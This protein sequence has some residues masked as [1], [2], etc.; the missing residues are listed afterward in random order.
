[1]WAVGWVRA[2][3]PGRPLSDLYEGRC[4]ERGDGVVE[5][6]WTRWT[7]GAVGDAWPPARESHVAVTALGSVLVH[8]GRGADGRLGD[9]WRLDVG[10]LAPPRLV[11]EP[12][13]ARRVR[14]R[15]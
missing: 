3:G 4:R 2:C 15:C 13:G 11:C 9:L 12:N 8:G 5:L 7:Q 6:R 14:R 10:A 1:M